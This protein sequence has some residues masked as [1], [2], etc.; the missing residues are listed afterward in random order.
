MTDCGK[1]LYDPDDANLAPIY[2]PADANLAPMVKAHIRLRFMDDVDPM[3]FGQDYPSSNT[4][5]GATEQA[6][7]D[8]AMSDAYD[9]AVADDTPEAY[10]PNA[11]GDLSWTQ[12]TWSYKY[13]CTNGATPIGARANQNLFA[14]PVRMQT[15]GT[16]IGVVT[17]MIDAIAF[18]AIFTWIDDNTGSLFATP[19]NP[20]T[21]NY[22][23]TAT[24]PADG[25]DVVTAAVYTFNPADATVDGDYRYAKLLFTDASDLALLMDEDLDYDS[26]GKHGVLVWLCCWMAPDSITLDS[27]SGSHTG[28]GGFGVYGKTW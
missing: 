7:V 9:Y 13:L 24:E 14:V 17:D 20:C 1:P 21:L 5:T 18:R 4:H 19:E 27:D 16:R 28:T 12:K 11:G 23:L 2:D 8:A 3:R 22:G 10:A 15:C 25:A 6:A 26:T